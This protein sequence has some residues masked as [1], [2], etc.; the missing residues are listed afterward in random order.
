MENLTA[1][2]TG[3][4][5]VKNVVLDLI[6]KAS[7]SRKYTN[8]ASIFDSVDSSLANFENKDIFDSIARLKFAE[9][10]ELMRTRTFDSA[11]YLLIKSK[12][13]AIEQKLAEHI[14]R[15]RDAKLLDFLQR[16]TEEII[17]HSENEGER[18]LLG[19]FRRRR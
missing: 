10:L 6:K 9:L 5:D 11:R 19:L 16:Q 18:G 15:S 8:P 2:F 12:Y 17:Q 3:I 7:E 14:S 4:E 1:K 13:N